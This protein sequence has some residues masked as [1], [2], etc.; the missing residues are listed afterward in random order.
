V[1]A[2]LLP[3]SQ[4]EGLILLGALHAVGKKWHLDGVGEVMKCEAMGPVPDIDLAPLKLQPM[5]RAQRR[6]HLQKKGRKP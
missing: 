1:S 5:N 3:S 2:L 6:A 4:F